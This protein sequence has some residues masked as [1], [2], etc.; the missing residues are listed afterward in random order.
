MAK[1]I[2][3]EGEPPA[4]DMPPGFTAE[5]VAIRDAVK[6]SLKDTVSDLAEVAHGFS[7]GK[8]AQT[9]YDISY[10]GDCDFLAGFS[11]KSGWGLELSYL[12]KLPDPEM[13]KV[14]GPL[15]DSEAAVIDQEN[16]DRQVSVDL[17]KR[18]ISGDEKVGDEV[19]RCW[20]SGPY[21]ETL[22]VTKTDM[23]GLVDELALEF[24]VQRDVAGETHMW[25][26]LL[27]N[28]EEQFTQIS[29]SLEGGSSRSFD[30]RMINSIKEKGRLL[31]SGRQ[32][33]PLKTNDKRFRWRAKEIPKKEEVTRL[34][35]KLFP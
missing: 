19:Q 14:T 12:K 2:R 11:G 4:E 13:L 1:L 35:E 3:R 30:G 24:H 5:A 15:D 7:L 16:R 26:N 8:G 32:E 31:E 33:F 18:M 25:V 17:R 28:D 27:F 9:T 6:D 34:L 29:R 23:D 10:D 21:S 22:T 20:K